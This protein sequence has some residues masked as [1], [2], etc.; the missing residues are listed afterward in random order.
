MKDYKS[1]DIKLWRI[2]F[3]ELSVDEILSDILAQMNSNSL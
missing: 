2:K 1:L 3:A